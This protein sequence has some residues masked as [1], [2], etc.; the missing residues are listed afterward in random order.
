MQYSAEMYKVYNETRKRSPQ[1]SNRGGLKKLR[2]DTEWHLQRR[3]RQKRI[4]SKSICKKLMHT[5]CYVGTRTVSEDK[6]GTYRECTREVDISKP[7]FW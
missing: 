6:T 7:L 1:V 4:T 3:E 5:F 2:E